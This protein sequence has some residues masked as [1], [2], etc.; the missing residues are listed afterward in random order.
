MDSRRQILNKIADKNGDARKDLERILER[1][2]LAEEAMSEAV[3]T[4]RDPVRFCDPNQLNSAREHIHNALDM[5]AAAAERS[6]KYRLDRLSYQVEGVDPARFSDLLAVTADGT[7]NLFEHHWETELFPVLARQEWEFIGISLTLRS[8]LIPGLRLARRLKMG[9]YHVVLGGTAIAKIGERLRQ[10]PEFFDI[11]ANGVVT[12]EGESATLELVEQLRGKRDY[13]LVPNFMY[14]EGQTIKTTDLHVENY[15]DLPTPDFDG[16]PLHLY[17]SPSLVLPV[18]IGKGC[19]HDQCKFCD[20][21]FINR[22]SGK[23]YRHRTAETVANDVDVLRAKYGCAHFFFGDEALPP[24]LLDNIATAIRNVKN[25]RDLTFAGY[26]RLE[27][28][29]TQQVCENLAQ[30]GMTRLYFGLESADQ[31]TL[32]AMSKGTRIEHTRNV[33]KNCKDAGIRFHLFAMIGFPKE[34][35]S[36][37]RRTI[38]FFIDNSDLFAEP[39]NT[40]DIH[41]LELISDTH[42]FSEAAT[43][44][45]RINAD[46]TGRELFFGIGNAWENSEGLSRPQIQ[47]LL[48]EA[49]NRLGEHF[50][51]HH[52]WPSLLWP[53]QE[54]WTL[55]YGEK[56]RTSAF[57]FRVSLPEAE[58]SSKVKIRWNPA[59]IVKSKGGT[60]TVESRQG[61]IEIDDTSFNILGN[62]GRFLTSTDIIRNAIGSTTREIEVTQFRNFITNATRKGLLQII[63]YR[64]EMRSTAA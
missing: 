63:P 27:P 57:N 50:S 11:F 55:F 3:A 43:L 5:V 1:G 31:H 30:M 46:L 2:A 56:Y 38:D 64:D 10:F 34:T 33:L 32:D 4:V 41:E 47:S 58:D 8:Q 26:A 54:E 17:L 29:F 53:G 18:L 28:G 19:Y 37:A 15:G 51:S 25:L 9:G 40:F 48:A 12:G 59:A 45:L 60:V 7:A 23:R 14:E 52:A 42:Y 21:P 35:E 44:G 16:M 13:S 20:I 22:K 36:S 24:Y 6:V 61:E 49:G 62:D 39:G